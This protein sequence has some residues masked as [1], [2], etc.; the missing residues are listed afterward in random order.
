MGGLWER[1][2]RQRVSVG[3]DCG[4]RRRVGDG[5]EGLDEDRSKDGDE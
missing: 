4:G 3:V 2:E 1:L 5:L